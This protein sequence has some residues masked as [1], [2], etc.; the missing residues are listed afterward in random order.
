M[1]DAR[2]AII[3]SIMSA[4][5]STSPAALFARAGFSALPEEVVQA[6]DKPLLT[7]AKS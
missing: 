4:V 5:R 2:N 1:T 3:P 6:A 7:G